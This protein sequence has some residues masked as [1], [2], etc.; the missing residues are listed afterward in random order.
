MQPEWLKVQTPG[1][2]DIAPCQYGDGIALCNEMPTPGQLD[3]Y[4]TFLFVP[5]SCKEYMP[6]QQF[7]IL[8]TC[9]IPG[10]L[11]CQASGFITPF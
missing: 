4:H 3:P 1:Q 2:S 6:I 10:T 8:L 9:I 11:P 5:A 7:S